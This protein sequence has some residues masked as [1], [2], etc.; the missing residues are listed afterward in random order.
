M[1]RAELGVQVISLQ[2]PWLHRS[3]TL[4]RL[5]CCVCPAWPGRVSRQIRKRHSSGSTSEDRFA[6][7]AR[8]YVESLHQN[9]RTHLLYGKNNVLVQPVSACSLGC[10]CRRHCSTAGLQLRP[11]RGSLQAVLS[12]EL[13][14]AWLSWPGVVW[15]V[16]NAFTAWPLSRSNGPVGRNNH[17][18][19]YFINQLCCGVFPL[20]SSSIVYQYFCCY[21]F[22][23]HFPDTAALELVWYRKTGT[24][25]LCT[26][27]TWVVCLLLLWTERW[28]GGNSWLSLPSSISR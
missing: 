2:T 5:G 7:S 6:A 3:C 15:Q 26:W 10:P 21:C 22:P 12:T 20:S 9:S 25:I 27:V 28:L 16:T 4:Q 13:P 23:Q 24:Y 8:E 18:E 17:T 19:L 14:S 1:V 11:V